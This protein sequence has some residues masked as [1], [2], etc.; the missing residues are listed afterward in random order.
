M[1]FIPII[2][3]FYPETA[4]M[5]L[6][7]MDRMFEIQSDN[8]GMTYDEARRLAKEDVDATKAQIS[9]ARTAKEGLKF[10]N[11]HVEKVNE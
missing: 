3:Y 5:S 10:T 9:E 8:K 2:Y 4:N 7:E 1:S 6:D 11:V